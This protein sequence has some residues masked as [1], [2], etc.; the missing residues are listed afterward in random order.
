MR[1][2]SNYLYYLSGKKHKTANIIIEKANMIMEKADMLVYDI[3]A[4][5][6][7]TFSFQNRQIG[8]WHNTNF[9]QI[10]P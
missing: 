6:D 8:I 4:N 9:F 3:N 1:K 7:L 5:L 10:W 2:G